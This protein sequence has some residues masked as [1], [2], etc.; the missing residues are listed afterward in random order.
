M[1][2][3]RAQSAMEYLVTYGWAIIII[4]V[5]F[6]VLYFLGVF[7]TN[8]STGGAPPGSC[9]VYKPYGTGTQQFISL[10]GT[11]NSEQPRSVAQF[12]GTGFIDMGQPSLLTS[13][14]GPSAFSAWVYPTTAD[15]GAYAA[16]A[17]T[18]YNYYWTLGSTTST[19][20]G[21]SCYGGF[22]NIYSIS[23]LSWTPNA[24]NFIA[25]TPS[26]MYVNGQQ[27]SGVG[28]TPCGYISY[29]YDFTIGAGGD[30]ASNFKGYISNVQIYNASLSANEV[31]QM[32]YEG[33]G[34]D[35]INIQNLVG[36]WPLN[37]DAVDYSG[38]GNNGA[39]SSI[40]FTTSWAST[41][42]KP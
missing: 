4:V 38:N 41:Y 3:P 27:V 23:P 34:G 16:V 30:G 25:V 9:R 17:G 15:V 5:A 24:W 21:S 11:C 1:P 14:S 12:S 13:I 31:K 28:I 42:T 6:S 8:T 32:Y 18:L 33:I 7:G 10:Q 19:L 29:E 20:A 35:P 26:N 2:I 37:G 36:W 40:S 39:P 22:G